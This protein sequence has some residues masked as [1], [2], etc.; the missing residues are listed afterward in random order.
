MSKLMERLKKNKGLNAQAM[1]QQLVQNGQEYGRDDRIWKY[2]FDEKKKTAYAKIRFLPIPDVDYERQEAGDIPEDV[3]LSPVACV[4]RHNFKG[5]SGRYYNAISPQTWGETCPVREYDRAN[6]TRQKETNDNALKE[7]LKKRIPSRDYYANILV[8]E[9]SANPENNGKVF[10]FKFGN[11]IKN[12]LDAA[13]EP[14][15]P[16]DPKVEDPFCVF[17]GASLE[18]SLE[19]EERTFGGWTGL[20]PKDFGRCKWHNPTPLAESEAEIEEIMKRT[21]SIY[22]FVDR[23]LMEPYEVLEK[24]FKEVMGIPV[25]EPLIGASVDEEVGGGDNQPA[26]NSQKQL[27]AAAMAAADLKKAEE[28]AKQAQQ[29]STQTSD[30]SGDDFDDFLNSL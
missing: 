22:D 11:A 18:I 6:W 13:P 27:D 1:K 28:Q 2:T 23:K 20:V 9:D 30:G 5:P 4:Q 17:E 14:K 3:V 16:G 19:G 12:L 21:Y 24:R 26:N 10:L 15:F 29:S 7:M 25:D 8:I